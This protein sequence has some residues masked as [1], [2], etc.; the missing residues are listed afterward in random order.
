MTGKPDQHQQAE[1]VAD[2]I[3][4]RLGGRIVLALPLGLG[5]ANLVANALFERAVDDK[6]IDLEIFTALTL[7]RPSGSSDMERRFIE[8]LNERLYSGYPGLAFAKA[9]RDGSLPENVRVSEFFFVA[10]RW[11]SV[12]NAQQNYVSA[13][14]THAGR[15]VLDRGINVVA[16]LVAK[17]GDGA[18]AEYSLSCNS[19]ITLD[20]LPV[21]KARRE[22]VLLVGEVS[23][24]LPFMPGEAVL[25][26]GE[27]DLILDGP[28]R[29]RPLFVVPRE[30][31]SAADHAIGIHA[32]GL[33]K[34][35]GTLQIGIGSLGDALAAGLILRQRQPELFA[36][37]LYRLSPHAQAEGRETGSFETG[38]YAASEMFVDGFMDLYREGILKRRVSDGAILHSGFFLGSH[39]FYAFLR[40]LP[41]EERA[42]FQ[43]RG[44]SFV[45][46]LYGEEERKRAD[47]AHA[48]FVNNAMMVTL[49]GATVSDALDDGRVVSGVGGQYNFVAQAFALEGA[50]SIITL[51]AA[52]RTRG[53]RESRL[54][55]SYGHTTL[56]RHL[57]DIVVTEYGV[58]DLRG[59]SDRDCIAAMLAIADSAF[60][61]E[62]LDAAKSAG[63]IEKD[64]AV[65]PA[66]RRNTPERIAEALLPLRKEG[67]CTRFP[68][69]TEFTEEEQRLIP[70]LRH[71]KDISASGRSLARAALASL[72]EGRPDREE[73]A[74]LERMQL[75]TPASLRETFYAKLLL[76]ALRHVE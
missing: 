1:S 52:R 16:Q 3:I 2:R 58:A 49:M 10:G 24:Q 6:A 25:P 57:R 62:L 34:D 18:D 17:R 60:Q 19:D 48:R 35:G 22:P 40:D 39:E 37:T 41:E 71:L 67:W 12:E 38:L 26:A 45:N 29:D 68:F 66:F 69:A 7:E 46:E 65:P 70:A 14:Y 51:N 30:P 21:L 47:R 4:E 50:H 43:M 73:R 54:V 59:K 74:A 75:S 13:N 15:Y 31:V 44:I 42:L 11:L 63:K 8:P 61:D 33:A 9:L 76:W 20:I 64:F 28:D 53:R 72:A 23:S 5:K 56:P 32:A 27:F 36:G 55:W